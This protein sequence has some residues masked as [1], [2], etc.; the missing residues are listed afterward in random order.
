MQVDINVKIKHWFYVMNNLH[1]FINKIVSNTLMY[2][3]NSDDFEV[4]ILLTGDTEIQRINRDFC[5]KDC[6]TNVLSFPSF[7]KFK[8][9]SP[10]VLIGDI[11]ISIDTIEKEADMYD[12]SV[13]MHFAH[14]LVH[15]IL[16]LV[17]Y[18]HI[19]YDDAKLM[20]LKES[21]IMNLLGFGNPY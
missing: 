10:G 13:E 8:D 14:M 17:G 12:R 5:N 15:S 7:N 18:D 4:S 3:Y 21:E 16:H 20:E 9:I 2:I 6:A 19:E 1:S 11:A